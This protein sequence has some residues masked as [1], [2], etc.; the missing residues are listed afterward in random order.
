MAHEAGAAI[1]CLQEAQG[2]A[3]FGELCRAEVAGYEARISA[4]FR[5]APR[6]AAPLPASTATLYQHT[7][8]NAGG[9][10]CCYFGG[11]RL[12][13]KKNN[14]KFQLLQS[15]LQLLN[16]RFVTCAAPLLPAF[17]VRNVRTGGGSEA[18]LMM[19]KHD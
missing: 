14:L 13:L 10:E 17:E 15:S 3:A 6:A 4:D 8:A 18:R 9:A 2:Q 11:T 5:R 12:M 1:R 19:S 7:I 16:R